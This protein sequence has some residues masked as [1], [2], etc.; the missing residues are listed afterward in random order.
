MTRE[1]SGVLLRQVEGLFT[2]GSASGL[3]EGSLLDRF[4]ARRDV[5][6]FAIIVS[7]HGPMVRGVCRRYLRDPNDADDAFQATFLILAR[8]AGSIRKAASL[9][10]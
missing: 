6:A 5:N 3:A 10:N 9:G 2:H 1:R 7:R 4:V 8:K